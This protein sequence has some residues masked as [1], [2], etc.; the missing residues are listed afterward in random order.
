MLEVTQR[1]L[2]REVDHRAMNVLALVQGIVRLTKAESTSA[3][4]KS[5]QARVATLAEIH[6]LLARSAWA[7][8]P[9]AEVLATATTPLAPDRIDAEGPT[10]LVAANHVQG[11]ALALRELADNAVR[12]G[13]LREATGTVRVTWMQQGDA[14]LATLTWT[15]TGPA[16]EPAAPAGFGVKMIDAILKQQLRGGVKRSWS[17]HGLRLEMTFPAAPA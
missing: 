4:A 9:L 1:R 17:E 7:D 10:L 15:E 8:V 14:P 16:P 2:L 12:H 13:S 6:G 3:Y 11:L 5:V